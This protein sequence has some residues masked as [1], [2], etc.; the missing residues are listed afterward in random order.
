MPNAEPYGSGQP[1]VFDTVSF[2]LT[3]T[4]FASAQRSPFAV[5]Q[6]AP[7]PEG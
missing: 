6:W 2:C 5:Q 3:V 7:R 4:V 1:L